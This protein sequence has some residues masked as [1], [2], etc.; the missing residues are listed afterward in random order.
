M[1]VRRID[2][3][4][5][6]VGAMM[7]F[8]ILV[9]GDQRYKNVL[10][11]AFPSCWLSHSFPDRYSRFQWGTYIGGTV[12]KAQLEQ[13]LNLLSGHDCIFDDFDE[14][15]ALDRH[16][17]HEPTGGY[18]R[19]ELGNLIYRAKSYG[20]RGG[21]PNCA[22]QIAAQLIQFVTAHPTFSRAD[23]IIPVPSS[24]P[25]DVFDLPAYFAGF[26]A[27]S[28]KIENGTGIVNKVRQTAQ[29][30]NLHTQQE[31]VE[32]VSRAFALAGS[33]EGKR[34]IVIDDLYQ[35]GAT[36]NEVGRVVRAGGPAEVLGL[37]VTK[38][39]RDV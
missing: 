10:R 19:T 11:R 5:V 26:M 4:E 21:D 35:S 8:L 15:F 7:G 25:G 37:A 36:I 17:V 18:R 20:G 16:W 9:N 24:K 22:D 1:D 33:V 32:N 28:L 29:Q 39:H 3:F 14:C 2:D 27:S 30:K 38:T 31:K 12:E 23:L 6:Q 13:V 34:V